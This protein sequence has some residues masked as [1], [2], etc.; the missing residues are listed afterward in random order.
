M[1]IPSLDIDCL[2]DAP[3]ESVC[4]Q[5]SGQPACSTATCIAQKALS[6]PAP[7]PRNWNIAEGIVDPLDWEADRW[8]RSTSDAAPDAKREVQVETLMGLSKSLSVCRQKIIRL[9]E[10]RHA[11]TREECSALCNTLEIISSTA[12]EYAVGRNAPGAMDLHLEVNELIESVA[13]LLDNG[14]SEL[15]EQGRSHSMA[16]AVHG[17]DVGCYAGFRYIL[18]CLRL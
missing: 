3:E 18:S 13:S 5:T 11:L 16:G 9:G 10:T 6:W 1:S 8:A 14:R 17:E 15:A 12:L 4:A 2:G 7:S